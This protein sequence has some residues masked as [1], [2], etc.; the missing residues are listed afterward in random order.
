MSNTK[1]TNELGVWLS[2]GENDDMKY[3][4]TFK[5]GEWDNAYVD[6]NNRLIVT[7]EGYVVAV[8]APGVWSRYYISYKDADNG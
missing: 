6:D 8:Y 5:S 7:L 3:P 1:T 4:C 2:S